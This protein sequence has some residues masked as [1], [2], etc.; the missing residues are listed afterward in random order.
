MFKKGELVVYPAHGIGRI[1][2]VQTKSVD[3]EERL[4][5]VVRILENDMKILLPVTNSN[6][7]GIRPLVDQGEIPQIFEVLKKREISVVSSSWNKR[8]REYREK[9]KSGSIYELAEVFRN[10]YLTQTVK[11]LSFGEKKMLDMAKSLIVKEISLV[12]GNSEDTVEEMI[13]QLLDAGK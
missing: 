7:V 4:F 8:Y 6:H 1:E 11:N 9:I 12:T 5:L 13:Y 3:G 2:D 10:L